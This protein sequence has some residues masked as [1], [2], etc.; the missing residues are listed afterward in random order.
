MKFSWANAAID[1]QK[2]CARHDFSFAFIG[3]VALQ[4][5]GEPRVTMD[6]DLTVF[7][8]FGNEDEAITR[9][10]NHFEPRMENAADFAQQNRVLLLQSNEGVGIDIALGALPFE[11]RMVNRTVEIEY[12]PDTFF[13][14]CC[15]EDLVVT[16]TFSGRGQDWVDL[17]RALVR[18][19]GKLNWKTITSELNELLPIKNA[20]DHLD[21]LLRLRE[22]VENY[23]D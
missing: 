14:I 3:A 9:F 16:K 21:Q 10:L 23:D 22:Q 6:V 11:Q 4:H 19:E 12:L 7:T 17:E 2:L 18:Q 20:E 13:N 8:G 15:A 5:W 1:V